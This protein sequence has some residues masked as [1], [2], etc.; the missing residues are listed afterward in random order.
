MLDL[1]VWHDQAQVSGGQIRCA[2]PSPRMSCSAALDASRSVS[3]FPFLFASC[4]TRPTP[5]PSPT[6]SPQLPST[7]LVW[8]AATPI[9]FRER[10][11]RG[12][13]AGGKGTEKAPG[14]RIRGGEDRRRDAGGGDDGV[15][16]RRVAVFDDPRF[17][18]LWIE[19]A[20]DLAAW[21]RFKVRGA[22]LSLYR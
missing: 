21:G 5:P 14:T 8:S 17:G 1:A 12:P 22:S 6:Y 4:C 2:P 3:L 13:T 15:L 9:T 10:G 7:A 18:W 19:L 16:A 11:L 20:P